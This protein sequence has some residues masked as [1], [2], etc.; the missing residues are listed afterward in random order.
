MDWNQ[1]VHHNYPFLKHEFLA[2]L[3]SCHCVGKHMGWIPKY[4]CCF[5]GKK[6]V[7][8][9]PLYEKYN[10]WGEFVFDYA[11]A[12]A[13]QRHG[14]SYYPK[15]ISAIPFTPS[16]G[17]RMLLHRDH[18][19]GLASVL[20]QA[21]KT[22]VAAEDYSGIHFLFPD[23]ADFS[24][25][26]TQDMV[27]RADCQFHW[28]NRNYPSFDNFLYTLKAKK[29]KNIR[30]ERRKVSDAAISIRWLNGHTASQA[31]WSEFTRLY[32][33]IYDRK[34]GM[35]AFN[36]DFF[37]AISQSMPDQIQLALADLDRRC[38]AGALMYSDDSTLYGRHWGCDQYMNSLHFELCY[39]QGIEFC[40]TNGLQRFDPGAQG[41]H[42][43][44]RGFVPTKTRS[45]HWLSDI[46]FNNAIRQFAQREQ[47]GVQHYI[48]AVKAHSPYQCN[49]L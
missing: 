24:L 40:I 33:K 2:A 42:K 22:L 34:Y 16:V 8:A 17:Q 44:A 6:L 43:V 47:V 23:D 15:L 46:P 3:E 13:Y 35:P 32:Q 19:P 48:D 7:A 4:L 41:E 11:W 37:S 9:L 10:S 12:D 21:A 26:N 31:D 1:M 20:I 45:L 14:I 25:I 36:A 49:S 29:R 27:C 5:Q 38:I 39:Y 30:Q 28:H 18:D